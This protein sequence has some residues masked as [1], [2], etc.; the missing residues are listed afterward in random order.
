MKRLLIGAAVMALAIN[1]TASSQ[2][3]RRPQGEFNDVLGRLEWQSRCSKPPFVLYDDDAQATT[4][5]ATYRRCLTDQAASDIG[6][7][8]QVITDSA[9]AELRSVRNSAVAAGYRWE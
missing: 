1:G 6:Y 5:Y 8:R 9:A 3:F 4:A 2:T 7:A